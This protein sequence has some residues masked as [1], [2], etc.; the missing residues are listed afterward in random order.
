MILLGLILIHQYSFSQVQDLSYR[1]HGEYLDVY[2]GGD[3]LPASDHSVLPNNLILNQQWAIGSVVFENGMQVANLPL[4]F[5]VKKNV[6]HFKKDTTVYAFAD[7]VRACKMT[8][9]DGDIQKVVLFRSGYP[10]RNGDS[11]D[12][13]YQV[14]TE[15]PNIHFLKFLKPTIYDHYEYGYA[16]KE[17]YGVSAESYLYI[18][19]TRKLVKISA[20]VKSI[21]KALPGYTAQ[22]QKFETDNNCKLDNDN[23]ITKLII[24]LNE[25]H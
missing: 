6:L 22:I 11:S 3:K 7:V 25:V 13:L 21:L 15:G 18:V 24:M 23:D 17:T 12:L 2:N 10:D 5:D 1:E 9:T 14:I 16:D 20:N 19:N 8:Y 4:Q